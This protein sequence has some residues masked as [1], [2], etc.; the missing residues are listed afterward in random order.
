METLLFSDSWIIRTTSGNFE[1]DNVRDFWNIWNYQKDSSSLSLSKNIE[2]NV[3]SFPIIFTNMLGYKKNNLKSREN[4]IL[5]VLLSIIGASIVSYEEITKIEYNSD[6]LKIY[7]KKTNEE[8][9]LFLCDEVESGYLV[10][11]EN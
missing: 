4:V 9:L 5:N 1:F 6:E 7:V 3:N 11:K 8:L 2:K 10:L